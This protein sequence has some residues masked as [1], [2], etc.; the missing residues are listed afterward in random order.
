MVNRLLLLFCIVPLTSIAEVYKNVTSDGRIVFSDENK[1]NAETVILPPT[2]SY[3]PVP[4]P[5]IPSALSSGV[6]KNIPPKSR[7]QINFINPQP[8]SSQW[9]GNVVVEA[10]IEPAL[11]TRAGH[12]VQF[13]LNETIKSE[14]QKKL[15]YQFQQLSRGEHRVS[16]VVV[17]RQ[18]R[19][20]ATSK[21]IIFY[22]QRQS[23]LRRSNSSP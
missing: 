8:K 14:P 17:N 3:Q 4:Y 16:V 6:E 10:N 23:I 13:I 22:V 2:S 12:Q 21:P 18:Q 19:I 9:G 15:S 7:Y 11:L 20:L 5:V 1:G